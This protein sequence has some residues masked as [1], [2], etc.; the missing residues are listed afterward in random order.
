MMM[1]D[2]VRLTMAISVF[3]RLVHA[4]RHQEAC[5]HLNRL[6]E[7]DPA[8]P[9]RMAGAMTQGIAALAGVPAAEL[10]DVVTPAMCPSVDSALRVFGAMVDATDF[11]AMCEW[12]VNHDIEVCVEMLFD[13]AELMVNVYESVTGS[14]LTDACNNPDCLIHRRI[15]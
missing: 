15:N 5:D 2:E 7:D 3:A 11:E 13:L 14:K 12:W 6:V 4:R 8:T 10:P 9:V 1:A